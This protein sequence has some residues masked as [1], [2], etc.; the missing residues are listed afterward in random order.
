MAA[1]APG[2]RRATPAD[3]DAILDLAEE[4][5]TAYAA[6]EPR[7]W[8]PAPDARVRQHAYLAA[9]LEDPDTLALVVPGEDGL[10]GFVVARLVAAPPVYDPGGPTCVVDDFAVAEEADWPDAGAAL[11]A[12]VRA[13]ALERRVAQVVVV[14]AHLDAPKRAALAAA[15]LSLASE[16]WVGGLT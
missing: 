10:R 15:G 7:F 16:W 14:T 4:R 8:N 13:W 5:R 1:P 2:V 12:A 6:Y 9:L 3:L 11:L